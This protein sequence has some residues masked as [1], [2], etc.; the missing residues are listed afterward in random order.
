VA[1]SYQ[2]SI[3]VTKDPQGNIIYTTETESVNQPP[4]NGGSSLPIKFKYLK[5]W[6]KD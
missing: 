3:S 2:K 6:W 4:N 5:D 1:T